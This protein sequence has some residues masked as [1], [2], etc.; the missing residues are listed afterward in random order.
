MLKTKCCHW[1]GVAETVR[2]KT[3]RPRHGHSNLQLAQ[4]F[5][6][7]KQEAARVLC[8]LNYQAATKGCFV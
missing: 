6:I 2:Y 4:Y 5:Y 7:K 8:G 1:N 3:E